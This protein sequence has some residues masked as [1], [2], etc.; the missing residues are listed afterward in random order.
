M[1][2]LTLRRFGRGRRDRYRPISESE[3]WQI[4]SGVRLSLETRSP[5]RYERMF[6]DADIS[7]RQVLVRVESEFDS[8]RTGRL[9]PRPEVSSG[10]EVERADAYRGE[11][12]FADIRSERR[13]AIGPDMRTSSAGTQKN[14]FP[15]LKSH[16]QAIGQ[17]V[18]ERR[19][20]IDHREFEVAAGRSNRLAG[21]HAPRPQNPGGA[22]IERGQ[23]E[24]EIDIA[25][26][27][28]AV[29]PADDQGRTDR[30]TLGL[31]ER[32]RIHEI[33]GKA[34]ESQKGRAQSEPASSKA[35]V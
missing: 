3:A 6:E 25:G 7:D 28:D 11:R 1:L 2:V 23:D 4:A 9:Q 35:V 34:R 16:L 13:G 32:G 19:R 14:G 33:A 12:D 20:L 18:G 24:M 10:V 8:T 30:G 29:A 27:I 17:V 21:A 31:W 22:R 15:A 26:G 5:L